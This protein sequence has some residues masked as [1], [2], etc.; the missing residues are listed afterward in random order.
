L[1][2]SIAGAVFIIRIGGKSGLRG[3]AHRLTTGQSD[4]TIRATVTKQTIGLSETGNLC[5]QQLQIGFQ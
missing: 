2:K 3:T 4:L 5:A 1:N